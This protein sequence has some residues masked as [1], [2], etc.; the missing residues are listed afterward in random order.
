M[1]KRPDSLKHSNSLIDNPSPSQAAFML[2]G[3]FNSILEERLF[4]G[5]PDAHRIMSIE[6]GADSFDLVGNPTSIGFEAF[7]NEV[8]RR[9]KKFDANEIKLHPRKPITTTTVTTTIQDSHFK[10]KL[11]APPEMNKSHKR[12]QAHNNNNFKDQRYKSSSLPRIKNRH[13]SIFS[14][15]TSQWFS[16]TV[17]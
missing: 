7:L 10:R 2:R 14:G 6:I 4:D 8:L 11:P 3:K 9:F 12:Q 17:H 16:T 1:L 13:Y 15:G 5:K